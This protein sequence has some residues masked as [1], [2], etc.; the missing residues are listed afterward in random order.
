MI[1]FGN[2]T[3]QAHNRENVRNVK[4]LQEQ[5]SINCG[6]R[7]RGSARQGAMKEEEALKK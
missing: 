6:L 2:I 7:L 4:I 3:I 1:Y 5:I